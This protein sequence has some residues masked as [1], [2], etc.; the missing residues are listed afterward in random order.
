VASFCLSALNG[1]KKTFTNFCFFPL[2]FKTVAL[3]K[4]E[5][6]WGADISG[7]SG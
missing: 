4:V 6:T 3:P 7:T 1:I 2:I 5:G